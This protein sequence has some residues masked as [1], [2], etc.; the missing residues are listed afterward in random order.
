MIPELQKKVEKRE[1]TERRVAILSAI[2][3][4]SSI[5]KPTPAFPTPYP[6]TATIAE[7]TALT[8]VITA[9]I[10]AIAT[11]AVI[12][13]RISIITTT[14]AAETETALCPTH[15]PNLPKECGYHLH[16]QRVIL[17]LGASMQMKMIS[18][19][20]CQTRVQMKSR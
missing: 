8:T 1:N 4:V 10:V 13:A 6:T 11:T 16:Q 15:P 19:S 14:A 5:M 18:I 7:I 9:T 3:S 17:H 12:H 20:M 2:M